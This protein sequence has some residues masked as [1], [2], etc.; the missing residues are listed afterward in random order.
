MFVDR[1]HHVVHGHVQLACG[2]GNDPNVGLVW[3]QPVDV[4]FLQAVRGQGLVH[5]P[6]QGVDRHLEHLVALHG[7]E[8]LAR[9]E[10]FRVFREAGRHREQFLVLAVG[11]QV[12]G[13]DAGLVG[14]REHHGAGPVAEQ[15]AGAAIGPVHDVGQGFGP[16]HQGMLR[17]AALDEHV[18]H[19]QRIDESGAH[20]LH[21]EGRAAVHVE[22]RLQQAGGAGKDAVGGRGGHDDEID[23]GRGDAGGVDGLAGRLF[24]Q[25]A[26]GLPFHDVPLLDAG[27]L[28]DPFVA[29]IDHALQFGIGQDPFG[30]MAAGA[31]DA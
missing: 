30:Q 16:H 22:P 2:G 6:A 4:R 3:H 23:V 5:D 26:G 7:H 15:H 25:I 19:A 10:H 18:G 11:V 12:R 1:Y 13:E 24:G 28:G 31:G 20:R 29:G 27:A 8:G 9:L 21:V 14:G 17:L